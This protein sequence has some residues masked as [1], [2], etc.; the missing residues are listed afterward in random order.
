M[1]LLPAAPAVPAGHRLSA[2]PRL[3]KESGELARALA[4]V[5]TLC[6][7]Y[8]LPWALQA[9]IA[10]GL[11]Q[12]VAARFPTW[13]PDFAAMWAGVVMMNLLTGPPLFKVRGRKVTLGCCCCAAGGQSQ[14]AA[15]AY[16][17]AAVRAGGAALNLQY[18]VPRPAAAPC[19]PD[20]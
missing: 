4:A 14:K 12:S 17:A 8:W 10:L 1:P 15:G 3:P 11:A 9:G 20:G 5:Q 6:F 2:P 18:V 13:G 7:S 19:C 16:A